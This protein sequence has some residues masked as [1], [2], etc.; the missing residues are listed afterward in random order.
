M[1]ETEETPTSSSKTTQKKS[2]FNS[3]KDAFNALTAVISFIAAVLGL[4]VLYASN[5]GLFTDMTN[6]FYAWFYNEK[7]WTGAFNNYP[8]GYVDM[9]SMELSDTSMQLVLTVN[10]GSIDGV[11]SDKR[12]CR[13]GFPHG[14]K[15]VEGKL[16]LFTDSGTITVW[17]IEQGYPKNYAQ[18][19][20]TRKGVTIEVTPKKN[21]KWFGEETVKIAQHPTITPDQAMGRLFSYCQVKDFRLDVP[22][23]N[24]KD[25]SSNK[26]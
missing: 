15:L 1:A 19:D 20:M 7:E 22:E 5:K 12:L 24:K 9:A 21:S 11:M 13:V 25:K 16:S 14:Y 3:I 8:E 2:I 4:L 23:N 26:P 17:D 6:D 18:F 10:R